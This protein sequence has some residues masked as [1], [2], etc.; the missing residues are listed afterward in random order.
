M[1]PRPGTWPKARGPST[2]GASR[3]STP[4]RDG[5]GSNSSWSGRANKLLFERMPPDRIGIRARALL[6]GSS[7]ELQKS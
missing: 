3:A 7:R 2:K 5:D 6:M 1:R 4:G